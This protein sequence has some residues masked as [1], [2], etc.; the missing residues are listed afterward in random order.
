MPITLFFDPIKGIG[1][2][3]FVLLVR[4][5]MIKNTPLFSGREAEEKEMKFFGFAL[6]DSMFAGDCKISRRVLTVDEA[7]DLVKAG[8]ESC[9]NPS[10]EAT[11]VAMRE[12]YGIE[13]AIPTT[14]PR[15]SLNKGDSLV[16]MSVRGLP[17][18]TDNRHYSAEEI[19]SATFSFAI[20][21][22]VE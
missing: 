3:L 20:Y 15:V 21:T 18:L 5:K 11:I 2:Y 6:A 16:V 10:H 13:V 1:R 7:R 9:L 12:K 22:V 8:V 17:R 19:A 4:R 14:P